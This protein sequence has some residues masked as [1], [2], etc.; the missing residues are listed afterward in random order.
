MELVWYS[1]GVYLCMVW[2]GMDDQVMSMVLYGNV[3]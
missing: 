1:N 2:F 3:M